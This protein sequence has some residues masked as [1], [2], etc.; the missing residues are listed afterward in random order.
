MKPIIGVVEWPYLDKDEDKIYEVMIPIIEW[1]VRSGGRPIGLFPTN[2]DN[3]VDK[4][5][6]DLNK[7]SEIELKELRDSITMCDGIIKPGATKIYPHE[8]KIY[9]YACD[10]NIPYLGICGGMQIMRN[11]KVPYKSNV[12]NNSNIIHHSHDEYA[13]RV[14]I[15]PNTKLESIIHR[16]EIEVNSRHNY[17]VP[18]PGLKTIAAYAPDGVIE[19]LEDDSKLFNIGVQWHP[20]LLPENDISSINL[21]GEFVESAKVYKKHKI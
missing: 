19:A 9:E 20:E 1:I 12:K 11:H 17:H 15:V 10:E 18:D 8:N 14:G 6:L 5:I 13:H 21:F 4:K 2:I 16:K 3:F 7:M